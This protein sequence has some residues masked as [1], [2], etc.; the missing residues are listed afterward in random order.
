[1]SLV[2]HEC[3]FTIPCNP[4]KA[5][6]QASARIMKRKDGTMF[7]GKSSSSKGKAVKDSLTLLLNGHRPPAMFV[8][9]VDV[10]ILWVY[11]WRSNEPKKNRVLGLLPCDKR[12]DIDNL[13]KMLFD[14]MT[15]I[16]F[17]KDD[18]QISD[19]LFRK[20]W[21]NDP[22]IRMKITGMIERTV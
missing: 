10:Y 12:P 19:L 7:V 16:G 9:P 6:H 3:A 8:G 4:P 15:L 11:P 22:G 17:W 2:E 14:V 20:R 13:C 18:S 21:G 5:T 1:M